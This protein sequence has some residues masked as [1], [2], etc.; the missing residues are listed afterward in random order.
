MSKN[1]EYKLPLNH[2]IA[3]YEVK[4]ENAYNHPNITNEEKNLIRQKQTFFNVC[5][6]GIVC[7]ALGECWR[8][9][10]M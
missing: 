5:R 6:Y 2:I 10:K 4:L 8:L 9:Y 1:L 3:D 7:G